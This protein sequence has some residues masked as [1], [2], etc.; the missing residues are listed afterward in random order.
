MNDVIIGKGN[1][2]GRGVYADRDS[3]AGE[4]VI[5]YSLTVLTNNEFQDLPEDEKMF[6]HTYQGV[7]RLYSE[8]E[9]YV[10]HSDNPNTY[11]NIKRGCDIAFRDIKKGEMITTD[12]LKDDL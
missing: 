8:P 2:S 12:A 4:M 3:K 7:R 10:N 9:R 6:V 11:Q 1:L 5:A